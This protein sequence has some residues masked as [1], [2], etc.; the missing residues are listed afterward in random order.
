MRNPSL[1]VRT[2]SDIKPH[3]AFSPRPH[4]GLLSSA[5]IIKD[6]CFLCWSVSA[7]IFLFIYLSHQFSTN[8]MTLK[9][10]S[11]TPPPNSEHYLF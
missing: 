8:L 9:K 3:Y 5:E 1:L 4:C 11:G 7:G 2:P 6:R 10:N